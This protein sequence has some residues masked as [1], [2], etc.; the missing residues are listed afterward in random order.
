VSDDPAPLSRRWLL[1]FAAIC[2]LLALA[3]AIHPVARQP[4]GRW[5]FTAKDPS[6]PFLLAL[7]A[8]AWYVFGRRDPAGRLE[9]SAVRIAPVA[10]AG[11][12]VLVAVAGLVWGSRAAGGADSYGYISEADLWLAGHLRIP[13]DFVARAPWPDALAS[14]APLGYRPADD[15]RA[16]V[17]VHAPGLP[18]LMAGAKA[19]LGTCAIF[20]IVPLAGAVFVLATYGIGARI[21]RP[22]VGFAAALL[23]A[24]SPT[25]LFMTMNP[26]SDLPAA[27][28]WT[29]ALFGVLDD[30]RSQYLLAGIAA[31]LAILIRP[32]VVPLLGVFAAWVVWR[33]FAAQRWARPLRA[34]A[35]W[36]LIPAAAGA[37]AVAAINA[38]LYGSPFVSGYGNLEYAMSHLP[39]NVLSYP[40]LVAATETPIALLGLLTLFLPMLWRGGRER[41]AHWLFAACAIVTAVPYLFLPDTQIWWTLRYWLPA[42]PAMM[43]GSVTL[44]SVL[45][46]AGGVWAR[47]AAVLVVGV[48]AVHGLQESVTRGVFDVGRDERKYVEVAATVGRLTSP[49]SVILSVQHSG[50]LR[51]YAGRMTERWDMAPGSLDRAIEWLSASGHHPYFVLEDWEERM[52]RQNLGTSD[53][54]ARSVWT[55]LATW[56]TRA[57]TIHLYDAVPAEQ[58]TPAVTVDLEASHDA[59]PCVEPSPAPHFDN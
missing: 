52:M 39:H 25:T 29:V 47:T 6:R 26:M 20:W 11:L 34:R 16:I 19:I 59:A 42:W 23:V 13:M 12:A 14:F 51:Y 37:L 28:A 36:F 27:A 8:A 44:V 32:N 5:T 53:A 33:D 45:Y 21:G 46:R 1:V 50:S 55:P 10:V 54:A 30:S 18:L 22:V 15:G 41:Q 3:V 31:A 56:R 58:T 38:R 7:A 2:A 49:A 48:L 17:P 57:T 40:A 43:I 9:S 4:I 24:V 35:W